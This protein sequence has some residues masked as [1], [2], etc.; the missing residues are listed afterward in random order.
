VTSIRKA[1]RRLLRWRRYAAKTEGWWFENSPGHERARTAWRYAAA[2]LHAADCSCSLC[3]GIGI[4]RCASG[5]CRCP[6]KVF[7]RGSCPVVAKKIR[8]KNLPQGLAES[9]ERQ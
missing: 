7:H 5:D 8:G 2:R 3:I 9:G 4:D 6:G 1:Y